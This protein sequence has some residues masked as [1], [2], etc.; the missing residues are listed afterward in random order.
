[1]PASYA[2]FGKR[3]AWPL[4]TALKSL[5]TGNGFAAQQASPNALDTVPENRHHKFSLWDHYRGALDNS[6]APERWVPEA[7][8]R[9][10][11]FDAASVLHGWAPAWREV[12]ERPPFLFAI[13]NRAES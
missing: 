1:M 3:R 10:L 11:D 13:V 4:R 8:E 7:F 2:V 5:Y 12:V 9:K 6:P